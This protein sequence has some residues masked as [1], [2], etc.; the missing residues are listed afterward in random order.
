MTQRVPQRI[1]D[2]GQIMKVLIQSA[3]AVSIFPD[4]SKRCQVKC[5]VQIQCCPFV[6]SQNSSENSIS[7]S[8]SGV[9]DMSNQNG[10]AAD[11][12]YNSKH[13]EQALEFRLNSGFQVDAL[14]IAVKT[15][16]VGETSRFF[17]L[18]QY[19]EKVVQMVLQLQAAKK[20]GVRHHQC[21]VHF[22]QGTMSQLESAFGKPLILDIQLLNVSQ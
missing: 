12:L 20:S 3:D 11:I 5:H 18:P 22:C 14:E 13:Q 9:I 7:P 10:K 2:D 6:Q 4:Y 21:A 8:G 17:I 15:M 19:S 16:K 1:T